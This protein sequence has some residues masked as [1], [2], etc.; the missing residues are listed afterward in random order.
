MWFFE[1]LLWNLTEVVD[2][3]DRGVFLEGVVD[4]VRG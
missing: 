2:E 4:A 1:K 3:T